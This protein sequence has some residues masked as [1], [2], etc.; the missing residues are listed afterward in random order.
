MAH[1]SVY[2]VLSPAPK[3]SRQRVRTPQQ[4]GA[5]LHY[6]PRPV[7]SGALEG[8]AAALK[9]R[10]GGERSDPGPRAQTVCLRQTSPP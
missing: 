8:G 5:S 2:G 9:N 7:C 6:S 3:L 1:G 4:D 10:S